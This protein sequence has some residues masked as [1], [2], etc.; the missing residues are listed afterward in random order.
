MKKLKLKKAQPGMLVG[1][2]QVG[3]YNWM[4]IGTVPSMP[5]TN[6][7]PPAQNTQPTNDNSSVVQYKKQGFFDQPLTLNWNHILQSQVLQGGLSA[8]ANSNPNSTSNAALKFNNQYNPTSWIPQ[9]PNT[10][11]QSMYG[12]K[13][14]GMKSKYKCDDGGIIDAY[15]KDFMSE[16][17]SPNTTPK[18]SKSKDEEYDE[19]ITESDV[20]GNL[21]YIN[22]SNDE[23]TRPRMSSRD[24]IAKMLGYAD[25]SNENASDELYNYANNDKFKGINPSVAS[26]TM[27]LLHMFPNLRLTSGIRNWGDKDAHPL[28]RAVDLAGD[29]ETMKNAHDYYSNVIVPKYGFNNAL[30]LVHTSVKNGQKF[31]SAPHIHLGFYQKGGMP[32]PPGSKVVKKIDDTRYQVTY[33]GDT[34]TPNQ[35][36]NAYTQALRYNHGQTDLEKE[37]KD[38]TIYAGIYDTHGDQH[39]FDMYKRFHPSSTA[40]YYNLSAKDIQKM[41]DNAGGVDLPIFGKSFS[42]DDVGTFH[43]NRGYLPAP[44]QAGVNS[45]SLVKEKKGGW[46]AGAVNPNHKGYCTPMSKPTCTGHRRAFALMMKKKHGF[47]KKEDGGLINETGYTEGSPTEN[48]PM[49]IIPTGDITM[50]NVLRNI[51]AIPV[52][53]GKAKSPMMMQPGVDY[54]FDSDYTME[55]DLGGVYDVSPEHMERLKKLGYNVEIL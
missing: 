26:A 39:T 43:M 52:K 22:A 35:M 54:A 33:P 31:T 18:K 27:E 5:V 13:K 41:R 2:P 4:S 48:N 46:L 11:L 45:G 32:I 30:P 9:N 25:N 40:Y 7:I 10:G 16:D 49:N 19:R 34:L 29:L 8:L 36:L 6:P 38:S 3:Q 20:Q 47:H 24:R 50:A 42:T 23:E 44:F 15:I 14:G 55:F 28:G 1:Q 12:M 53:N 17:A 51:M 21:D 37:V